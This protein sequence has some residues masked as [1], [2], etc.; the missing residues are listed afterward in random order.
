MGGGW[1]FD[2]DSVPVASVCLGDPRIGPREWP[3]G[4]GL[5]GSFLVV[6]GNLR[7]RSLG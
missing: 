1:G 6:G 3:L 7:R 4:L 2:E 5:L